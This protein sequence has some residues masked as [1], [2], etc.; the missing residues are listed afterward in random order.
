MNHPIPPL[1]PS[2]LFITSLLPLT[3]RFQQLE[4]E[5]ASESG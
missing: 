5:R 4:L 2:D 3:R 1:N